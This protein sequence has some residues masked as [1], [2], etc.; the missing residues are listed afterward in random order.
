MKEYEISSTKAYRK[1]YKRLSKSGRDV[2]N[3]EDVIDRL[4]SGEILEHRYQDHPLRGMF[5]GARECHIG[6][7]WLLMYVKDEGTLVLLLLRTGTHRNVL[8]ME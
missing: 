3:L 2:R 6:P 5:S 8:G 1:D 7:D 4:A